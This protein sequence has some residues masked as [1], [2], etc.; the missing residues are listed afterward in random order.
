MKTSTG[1]GLKAWQA[2][3]LIVL[4]VGL[5]GWFCWKQYQSV[6][7][8]QVKPHAAGEAA[9]KYPEADAVPLVGAAAHRKGE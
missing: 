6:T 7:Q 3:V 4:I 1:P 9:G 5:T 8:V 2:G